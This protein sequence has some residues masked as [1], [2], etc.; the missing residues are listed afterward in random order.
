MKNNFDKILD[1]G[2][3]D[4][5]LKNTI[6]EAWNNKVE[7]IKS[8]MRSEIEESVRKEYKDILKTENSSIVEA[9]NQTLSDAIA[10]YSKD[11]IQ[12]AKSLKQE[13]E[14]I[15]KELVETRKEYE[16]TLSENIKAFEVFILENLKESVEEKKSESDSLRKERVNIIKEMSDYKNTQSIK[17]DEAITELNKFTKE[18]LQEKIKELEVEKAVLIKEQKE[19]KLSNLK[20][21]LAL[22]EQTEE[23][24]NKFNLFAIEK[25]K[26]ELEEFSKDKTALNERRVSFELEAKQKLEEERVKFIN[27]S[28][29]LVAETVFNAIKT[30]M[31]SIKEEIKEASQNNFGRSIYEAFQQEFMFRKLGDEKSTLSR[32]T[33]QLDEARQTIK[34]S[35]D[36]I[37]KQNSL[38]ERTEHAARVA[39]NEAIRTKKMSDLLQGLNKS[40]KEIMESLLIN[41]KT[42]KLDESFHKLLPSVLKGENTIKSGNKVLFENNSLNKPRVI[43]G[44]KP[45]RQTPVVGE[46]SQ[47]LNEEREDVLRLA[48]LIKD[49]N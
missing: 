19:I 38:M 30:E 29:D 25:L 9:M 24:L 14:K 3:F 27:V 16:S 11:L 18:S 17:L 49:K 40:S 13:K 23:N 1:S 47:K 8:S 15:A 5:D 10:E 20:L 44:D 37:T 21:Q 45:K 39:K 32:L 36:I 31:E 2:F 34:E 26:E 12:E 22:K 43:T 42:E 46:T 48:G 33:K 28:K 7:E 4:E 41:T 35:K 6:K